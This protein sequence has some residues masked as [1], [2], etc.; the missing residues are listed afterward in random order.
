MPASPWASQPLS[1]EGMMAQGGSFCPPAPHLPMALP[2]QGAAPAQ[3]RPVYSRWKPNIDLILAPNPWPARLF[4]FI[5]FLK[6]HSCV[7]R[8]G[9]VLHHRPA[10]T[11]PTA[12]ACA[13]HTHLCPIGG[14][15]LPHG[16]EDCTGSQ[17]GQGSCT[18]AHSRGAGRGL[19]ARAPGTRAL[20]PH[21][22]CPCA[23]CDAQLHQTPL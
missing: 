8:R 7:G 21:H 11:M 14:S 15:Q 6:K 22:R 23:L 18:G 1:P 13:H 2:Q 20:H 4:S 9:G 5:S 16:T 19:R 12:P 3:P 10:S 17:R